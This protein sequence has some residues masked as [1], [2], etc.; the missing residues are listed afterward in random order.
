M[1]LNAILISSFFSPISTCHEPSDF[2]SGSIASHRSFQ[3]FF[4]RPYRSPTHAHSLSTHSRP[5]HIWCPPRIQVQFHIHWFCA[6]VCASV[7]SCESACLFLYLYLCVYPSVSRSVVLS[8]LLSV[9][10]C[11]CD[12]LLCLCRKQLCMHTHV[13]QTLSIR[14]GRGDVR[15][16]WVLVR[17]N[18]Y[19]YI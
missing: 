9:C 17:V 15:W 12:Q 2:P 3:E 18:K 1:Y 8:V 10:V 4:Q 7:R 6:C 19:V 5:V 14:G 11:D 16:I 13:C